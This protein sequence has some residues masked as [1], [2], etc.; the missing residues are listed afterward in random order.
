[1][2]AIPPDHISNITV[3]KDSAAIALYGEKGEIGVIDVTTKSKE[4]LSKNEAMSY[5][6]ISDKNQP[7]VDVGA[8]IR[9]RKSKEHRDYPMYI[10]DGE[11]YKQDINSFNRKTIE[12]ITVLKDSAAIKLYGQ[13]AGSGVIVIKTKKDSDRIKDGQRKMKEAEERMERVQKRM[14]AAQKRVEATHKRMQEKN[15]KAMKNT[16]K[17]KKIQKLQQE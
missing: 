6:V 5:E 16:E 12:S 10:V 8:I 2:D 17:Q 15:E 7:L 4:E 9:D 11:E 13:K 1:M 14:N 3:L